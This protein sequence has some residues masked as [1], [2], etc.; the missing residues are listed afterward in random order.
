[1]AENFASIG[2]AAGEVFAGYEA[3]NQVIEPAAEM[4]DRMVGLKEA[5]LANADALDKYK[6]QADEIGSSMP[7]AGGAEEALQAMTELY[8]TFRDDK[9]LEEQTET[10]AK[11]AV[12]MGDTAPMSAKVL[13]SAVMNLGDTSRPATEQMKE[14]G[15][16]IAV[17]QA[18]FPMGS[19]GLMRMAMALRML[20]SAAKVNNVNQKE[21]FAIMAEGNR[22]SL[23][24]P[25][26]LWSYPCSHREFPAQ[27]ERWSL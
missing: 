21:M 13:S 25:A 26:W 19:G 8:K 15:D 24:W 23:G 10:A 1:M 9:S 3:L 20:G 17:F 7:L 6:Q 22:I 12:V 5:T 11:L 2:M 14:F 18:R 27:D 4:Q 16:E